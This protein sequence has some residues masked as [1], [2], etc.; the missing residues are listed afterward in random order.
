MGEWSVGDGLGE[1]DVEL[2]EASLRDAV[3]LEPLALEE[4]FVRCPA[5]IAWWTAKSAR[6]I[7]EHLRSKAR[8]K[9]LRGLL[10]IRARTELRAE[11]DARAESD[12]PAEE[13]PPEEPAGKRR[14][15]RP[16]AA[17]AVERVTESMVAARV[18]Q[19]AEWQ[20]AQDAEIGAEVERERLKGAVLAL[21]AKKDML[22]Q[23]G[24]NHRAEMEREPIIRQRSADDRSLGRGRLSPLAGP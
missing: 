22:V 12:P 9:K 24:A 15:A 16:R 4:E 2:L 7:G 17:R 11:E 20:A 10:E 18:E 6:A 23:M 14:A 1:G 8:A 3:R 13:A 19:Y 5:D 21:L